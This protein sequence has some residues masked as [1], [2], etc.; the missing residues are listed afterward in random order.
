M[1]VYDL[2]LSEKIID[3][4]TQLES[5][6]PADVAE[7]AFGFYEPKVLLEAYLPP[8][9]RALAERYGELNSIKVDCSSIRDCNAT[10]FELCFQFKGETG[11]LVQL[12]VERPYDYQPDKNSYDTATVYVND[13][14]TED[15]EEANLTE[16]VIPLSRADFNCLLA[17]LVYGDMGNLNIRAFK[18]FDW[19]NENFEKTIRNFECA[20]DYSSSTQE[21]LFG[22]ADGN[23]TGHLRV[24]MYDDTMTDIQLE[25]VLSYDAS[26]NEEGELHYRKE[27]VEAWIT[28]LGD[29]IVLFSEY[30]EEDGQQPL[31]NEITPVP[32]DY[33]MASDF[34]D[35]QMASLQPAR[36][37]QLDDGIQPFDD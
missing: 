29:P 30:L 4:K 10:S 2:D 19:H 33:Q 1:G 11:P 32:S 36:F 5:D 13:D 12:I 21:Y 35:Q 14:D 8:Q 20:A 3:L 7:Y 22:D 16:H 15:D 25:R 34:A 37:E 26:A 24:S 17:S 27:V 23:Y 31:L 28:P 9:I 6:R 18:S